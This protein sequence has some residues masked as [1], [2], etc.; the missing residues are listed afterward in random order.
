MT[1]SF[2][3]SYPNP[4]FHYFID[5]VVIYESGEKMQE[6]FK[7][8]PYIIPTIPDNTVFANSVF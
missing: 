8:I 1:V 3:R 2:Q 6:T 5:D 7:N 4:M